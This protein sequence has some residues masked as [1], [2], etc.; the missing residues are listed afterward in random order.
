MTLAICHRLSDGTRTVVLDLLRERKPR[1]IPQ[2]VVHEFAQLLKFYGITEV[3]GDRYAGGFHSDEWRRNGI[4]FKPSEND[5]S[6]NYIR[7]LPLLL[8]GRA[9]LLDNKTLRSQTCALERSVTPNGHEKITHPRMANAHDDLSCAVA[10]AMVTADRKL[11][12]FAPDSSW[13]SGPTTIT[14][15]Q[16][17]ARR[18][19]EKKRKEEEEIG[20][21]VSNP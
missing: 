7:W 10:G 2:E 6:E 20:A 14:S 13:V 18:D 16:D 21:G 5:T 12:L 11:V 15:P 19:A 17:Q 9:R 4:V 3:W 1:F 8:S